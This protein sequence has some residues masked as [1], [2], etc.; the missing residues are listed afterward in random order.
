MGLPT[1]NRQLNLANLENLGSNDRGDKITLKN[2][3][4]KLVEIAESVVTKAQ[5]NLNKDGSNATGKGEDSIHAEDIEVDGSKMGIDIVYLDRLKF[6][7]DGVKGTEGGKG[8]YQFKT[9]WPNKKMALEILK[10]LRVRGK[11]AIKYKAIS[12]TERKDQ[13]LKRKTAKSDDLKG[14]AYAVA[15][16]IKKKGIKPTHF[17]T[18]AI[19]DTAKDFKKEIAAGFKLDI[20]ESL[21]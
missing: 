16:S 14:L 20:I 11:R 8:K 1:G 18:K 13:S 19:K 3:A 7:N 12:K 21:K 17:F 15:T 5:V 9:K 4:L 6:I 10:W 2:T